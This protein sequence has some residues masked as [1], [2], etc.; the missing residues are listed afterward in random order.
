[1][2][3]TTAEDD[4]LTKDQRD[5]HPAWRGQVAVVRTVEEALAVI[6]AEVE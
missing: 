1:M 6:G 3:Y 5:W 2:S 4:G